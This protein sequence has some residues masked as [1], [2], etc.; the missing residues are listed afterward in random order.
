MYEVLINGKTLY[1]PASAEYTIYDAVLDLEVGL[2][3]EFEFNVPP[4]NPMYSQ[5]GQGAVITILRDNTEFWRGEVKE[6][7]VDIN[8]V[9]NV[10]CL[11]DLSWLADEFMFPSAVTDETYAQ[12]FAAALG[13]YN[14]DRGADRQFSVGYITNVTSSNNCNWV[15]EYDWSILDSLRNCIAGDDGYLKVRRVT[16]GGVV[17]RYI[18]CVK[19]SDYGSL[20]TQ[21]ITFGVNLLD[22]LEEMK[23]DNFTNDLY[24]YGAETD[25]QLYED[26]NQRLAGTH[27][28]NATSIGAYGKH[29]KAVI[30]ET[31]DLTTLNNLAQAYLTR[32]SQPQLT[33]KIDALDLAE[34]S[35][36]AHFEIGDAIPVIAEP[37]AIDQNLYLTQQ[38]I[39]LQDVSK[40]KVTLSSY[41]TR[42]S[43]LTSQNNAAADAIKK[44]PSKSS[45][46]D[47]AK[48]NAYEIL[49]GENG[50]YVT[51]ETNSDGQITELRIANN[52]DFDRATKCWRWNLNG[53]AYLHRDVYTDDWTVGIA[54]TMDGG[55]V[56]DFITSGTMS[57]DRLDGGVI[58]GQQINGGEING[59]H[60]KSVYNNQASC[61]VDI[62]GGSVIVHDTA[63]NYLRVI[64]NDDS[65]HFLT[66][67][68]RKIA[69]S[70]GGG[71]VEIDTYD[72]I[73]YLSQHI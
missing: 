20:S 25:T 34:I 64:A 26:Y 6:T 68:S 55:I 21:S 42:G 36:N 16:S 49:T 1:Y 51:F 31:D 33:L 5:I 15:T 56:A 9:M 23:L 72:A 10:Y 12:R 69:A 24:P 22:Y 54:A 67:G 57:C 13:A 2:A 27:I 7:G 19:L 59:T 50:G 32:Y 43:T 66:L 46:L 48:R 70:K 17:T 11:E 39:D 52:L 3:G 53:L 63:D 38:S 60:I 40:N 73:Y 8:K 62:N 4:T 65:G 58:N 29:S 28:Q 44:I 18:D 45:I 71:Y 35:V 14:T 41:I 47:A 61:Y 37:F 30:F